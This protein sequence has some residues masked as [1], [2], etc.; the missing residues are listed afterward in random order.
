MTKAT[1]KELIKIL[2][3]IKVGNWVL[4]GYKGNFEDAKRTISRNLK[5]FTIAE[6]ET[7]IQNITVVS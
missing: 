1:K 2:T 3:D 4:T 7:K 6:L 5:V